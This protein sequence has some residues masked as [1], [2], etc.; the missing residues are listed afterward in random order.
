MHDQLKRFRKYHFIGA[1][2]PDTELIPI[3]R[4]VGADNLADELLF[5]F[6]NTCEIDWMLPGPR[7]PAGKLKYR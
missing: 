5:R 7:Q 4:T 3:S 2:P 1:N 6:T